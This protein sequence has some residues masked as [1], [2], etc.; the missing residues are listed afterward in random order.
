MYVSLPPQFDNDDC[1]GHLLKDGDNQ[2]VSASV[3]LG[4]SGLCGD[5]VLESWCHDNIVYSVVC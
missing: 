1:N 3:S 2:N 4:S 5:L